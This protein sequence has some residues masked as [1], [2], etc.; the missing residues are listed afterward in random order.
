[1][2][3]ANATVVTTVSEALRRDVSNALRIRPAKLIVVHNGVQPPTIESDLG[4]SANN[5]SVLDSKR[6]VA[7]GNIRVPKN[8]PLLLEAFALVRREFT[9]ATLHIVGQQDQHGLYESLQ[10]RAEQPDLAGSVVFHGYV[11]NPEEIVRR[12]SAFVLASTQEG[13]SLATIEAML[14]GVPV[15]TT[16]SGGPEEI[17]RDGETGLLVP[18]NDSLALATSL[19]RLLK[20][21]DF[22]LTLA[23]SAQSDA[24]TRF[25]IDAMVANFLGLYREAMT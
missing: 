1:M 14:M 12:A 19:V 18:V 2:L 3:A 4:L 13:F 22:A 10:S 24:R 6:V 20:D 5:Q 11:P 15:L 7:V 23:A 8:Y 9:Q 25:S 21:R 17:V 16:R